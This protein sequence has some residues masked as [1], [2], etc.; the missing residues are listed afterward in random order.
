MIKRQRALGTGEHS[1]AA[2]PMFKDPTNGDFSLDPASPALKLGF[3]PIDQ[4]TI[5]LLKK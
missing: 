1:I 4:S 3:V 2:D 5:G